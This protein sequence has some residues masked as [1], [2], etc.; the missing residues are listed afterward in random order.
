KGFEARLV[1]YLAAKQNAKEQFVSATWDSLLPLLKR[2]NVRLVLNGFEWSA[3]R[4]REFAS[5]IPYYIYRLQLITRKDEKWIRTW[6]DLR[7]RSGAGK[8]KVGVLRGT[9]AESYLRDTYGE[10]ID[11]VPLGDEGSTGVMQ[12]VVNGQLDATVQDTPAAFYYLKQ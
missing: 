6:Q 3:E 10:A 12:L 11:V 8:K 4:E 7:A 9:K 2:G 1:R 5:T